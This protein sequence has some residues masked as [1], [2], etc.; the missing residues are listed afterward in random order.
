M[1]VRFGAVGHWEAGLAF[2]DL[3]VH[4]SGEF[5][6]SR[7][8]RGGVMGMKG[9]RLCISCC[10]AP[11]LVDEKMSL[12]MRISNENE[13]AGPM[14]TRRDRSSSP[15]RPGSLISTPRARHGP[16]LTGAG[17][18]LLYCVHVCFCLQIHMRRSLRTV[19]ARN[20]PSSSY[21]SG[22]AGCRTLAM[23]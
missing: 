12:S 19:A 1:P 4:H 11:G 22:T 3:A 15:A 5:V 13:K 8:V 2:G 7:C 14:M 21:C 20:G 6:G 9:T 17:Q 16:A 18:M 23:V 10:Q